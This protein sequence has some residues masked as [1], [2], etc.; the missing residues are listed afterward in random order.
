M[1]LHPAL[2]ALGLVLAGTATATTAQAGEPLRTVCV[3]DRTT[4]EAAPCPTTTTVGTG[5]T[6]TTTSTTTTSTTK[7]GTVT[8]CIQG[9]TTTGP[10]GATNPTGIPYHEG[11]CDDPPEVVRAN[12]H[13]T[14]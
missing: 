2:L 5:T 14:G 6:S 4:G 7:P 9:H 1:R 12:P 3:N 11:P 10:K 13:F 8:L